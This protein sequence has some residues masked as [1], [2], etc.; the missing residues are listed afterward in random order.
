[1]FKLHKPVVPACFNKMYMTY[2]KTHNYNTCFDN[3]LRTT[4][5]NTS[6]VRATLKFMGTTVWNEILLKIS[7]SHSNVI[8]KTHMEKKILLQ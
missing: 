2:N 8:F 6:I 4:K 1:M 5:H 3:Y 7:K